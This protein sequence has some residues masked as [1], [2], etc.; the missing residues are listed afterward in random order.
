MEDEVIFR[1]PELEKL[2]REI[3]RKNIGK[4]FK[5]DW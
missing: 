5:K 2:W 1:E 4:H 3:K